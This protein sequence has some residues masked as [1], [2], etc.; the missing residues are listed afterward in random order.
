MHVSQYL[1]LTGRPLTKTCLVRGICKFCGR[2][3]PDSAETEASMAA[4]TSSG[5]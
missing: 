2:L 3:P 4:Y 5:G 1:T